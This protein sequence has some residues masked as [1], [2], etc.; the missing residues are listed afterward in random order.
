MSLT[1]Y[2]ANHIQQT[3]RQCIPFS[4]F[5]Q[6]ALY[7]PNQGY[8]CRSQLPIGRQGDFVT[9]P[10]I[11]P[12][13]SYCVAKQSL[14]VL[15]QLGNGAILEFGAGLGTLACDVLLYL[16][17]ENALP[18]QYLILEL[19][20]PLKAMQQQ[21]IQKR[22]PHLLSAVKWLEQL[23]DN[24]IGVII[25]NEVLD[26]MP[27]EIIRLS[28]VQR[29]QACVAYDNNQFHWQYHSI[30]NEELLT[31]ANRIADLLPSDIL[32]KGY[33]TEI[34]RYITPWINSLYEILY[35]GVVLL[36]DYGFL[37]QEYYHP[38]RN[39]GT[40]MCHYQHHA[41]PNPLT[42]VGEQDIT[43]HVDFSHVIDTA[44]KAGFT[45]RGF[46]PQ[47]HF[48]LSLGL[49]EMV[50]TNNTLQQ[51]EYAQQ[52]KYLTL[53]SE[54]GQLFKVLALSKNYDPSLSGFNQLYINR[55]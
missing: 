16:E 26:A 17:K 40:L 39:Q 28:D 2:I 41:H 7:T 22:C 30:T 10:E 37:Q 20:A 6:L 36:I 54:M 52:I 49:L 46:S 24:F 45:I 29:E 43:A 18:K 25:A 31:Q 9:A 15:K 32:K 44:E 38:D 12:L 42:H 23:P 13:F 34:N 19:S 55:T 4:E 50:N 21:T 51:Y 11:S 14:E 47:A 48:L 53:P 35:Q 33:V 5:M 3:P 8:Y 27:V 1:E